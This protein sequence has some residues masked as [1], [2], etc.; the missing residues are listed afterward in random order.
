MTTLS[1]EN[2]VVSDLP[3][4][5]RWVK[6]FAESE[7]IW[8]FEGEMGAGKTTFIQV[9]CKLLGVVSPV[10]S[11]TFALVNEYQTPEGEIY[12]FD[13]Y[14]IRHQS[15]ALDLGFEEYLDSGNYCFIE[16]ASQVPD[17]LPPHYLKISITLEGQNQ[18]NMIVSLI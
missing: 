1:F 10:Q 4:I 18:R 16:W 17:L 5:A 13:F 3:G 8:V 14:R 6:K 11:P 2:A 9:L 15:E 7:K 12:H